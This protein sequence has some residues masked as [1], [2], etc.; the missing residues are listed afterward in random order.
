[1]QADSYEE[2]SF[3]ASEEG[4]DVEEYDDEDDWRRH[5]RYEISMLFLATDWD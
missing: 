4:S 2:D 3:V 5:L 1:V